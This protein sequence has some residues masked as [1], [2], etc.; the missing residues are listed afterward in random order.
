M[1][2]QLIDIQC[3]NMKTKKLKRVPQYA[4]GADAISNWGN[5]SGVD[6]ANVV[7]Q[8]VGAVGSMIGNATSGKKPTAAGVIGGIG[9]GAAMGASIG[10][11]WGAVIGGAIG[12][13]TSGMGSGGSVNEL[14][15]EYQDPSGIAGLF[16]HSKS[17]I[18]N[19]AG[20]IKNGIQARQMSELVAADY[21]Q[22]NG[23]NELSLSKGGVVPSTMA[24]LDDGEMLRM[25][26]GTIGSIPEEGKPTDSN[27]LNVPVGTQVLS[28]K[29]KVPGT[30]KTFAE[31]GKKLMKKSKKKVN[32]IYAENSLMLNERN[33]QATY[34]SLLE[35][36]ESL[37]NK[38]N[39]KKQLIPSYENGTSGVYGRKKVKLKYIYDP[40]LGGFG[41]I[42]PNT[43][44]FVEMNDIR[45]DLLPD[46]MWI[47][48]YNDSEDI[49]QPITLKLDTVSKSTHNVNKRDFLKLPNKKIKK[50]TP[51]IF[52]D[53]AY[54]VAGKKYLIGDTF[55]YKGKQ[56]KVTG[57][58]EA[59]PVSKNATDL[60]EINDGFNWN[61]YR[62]VF[63]Q[64]EPRIIG[65]SG[66]GRY[67][68]YLLNKTTNSIPNANDPY[69]IGNM[70]MNGN[71][72]DLTVGK[73]L[74][75]INPEF[76]TPA[77][78][79][80]GT[81][82][83][84]SYSIPTITQD[85]A[86]PQTAVRS[87]PST[88]RSTVQTSVQQPVLEQVTGPIQPFSNDRPSLTELTSKP[89]KVLPKLNI[90]R[91]FVYNPS[92][93]DA[94]SN[95]LDM[96][97]LYS[98]VATL[99]PLFDR[100]RAEKVD[101]YT[102]NPVYGPTNYNIDPILREATL[103]DRIARYNMAN[104][105]PN[106]GAN[107][108]FGLQSA[109]NRN[110]TIANAYATKNNAE[111]QMAFNNAQ[112]AN[113][114]GQQYA[115]ARHIAATEYAQN[116]ANA[117]NI[118]RRNFASALNNWGASLRD[119]KQTSMD[120]AALEMLQPMLNYGT[121]DNVLNRVNKILNRVKNG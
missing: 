74:S 8:G 87:T 53:H 2:K 70:Y 59:V 39:S 81:N 88:K 77:L 103:S 120:M 44:G 57:N 85:T 97:S 115:D 79:V 73:R 48:N 37:K 22:E 7:T 9:S 68:T 105:N 38:K 13:I 95:G 23:Y 98:T 99:A 101:T 1:L 4:F 10:G 27:L 43:G 32:N 17:Y 80:I 6:K 121:E 111:N 106:T 14:T 83:S 12:G 102:Y 33:N 28:D 92:P 47:L 26:D 60:K 66:A 108:A 29:L 69:F 76:N 82:T 100:E 16:G 40:M 107:M 51:T 20:R 45:N 91:P 42:D 67:S 109:V 72:G 114:W 58:N 63:T 18:R 112:I 84:D 104:I 3:Y 19:K 64:G 35:L 62:D 52:N 116:K 34:L 65:P 30:N 31:M 41:Y 90:G 78:G 118:N 24:Y 49:E 15:G 71:W 86:I 36:Q 5:M 21:Y 119:K 50:N 113:Q 46:S 11:P 75:S 93:D 110:K 54:E 96:S 117:R 56:Y 25:P 55:E 89:S 94:V 61:L